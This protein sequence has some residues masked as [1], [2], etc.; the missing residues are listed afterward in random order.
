MSVINDKI[1]DAFDQVMLM[2]CEELF[3]GV[4]VA[5]AAAA[6]VVMVVE[7]VA[8]GFDRENHLYFYL[9]RLREQTTVMNVQVENAMNVVR[10]YLVDEFVVTC[11]DVMAKRANDF[12]ARP[13]FDA[14]GDP[15]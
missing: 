15:Y 11:L 9:S 14:L 8:R 10:K 3:Q 6:V 2:V 1:V 12:P 5:D 4:I 7:A 13:S